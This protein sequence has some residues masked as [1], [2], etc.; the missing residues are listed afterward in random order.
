L[1]F[2]G[3]G[4]PNPLPKKALLDALCGKYNLHV[5]RAKAFIA[6]E[7][8]A[9]GKAAKEKARSE[10]LAKYPNVIL[11][12]DGRWEVVGKSSVTG[13]IA[14]RLLGKL[15]PETAPGLRHPRDNSL[16]ARRPT[17]G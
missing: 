6:A 5:A 15:T 4:Y 17:H 8:I 13:G 3:H 7:K 1:L 10:R 12:A 9:K 11:N 14:R 16:I 2:Q